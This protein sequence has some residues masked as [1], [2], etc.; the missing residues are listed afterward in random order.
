MARSRADQIGAAPICGAIDTQD[1]S[2]G[3]A[4]LP[5]IGGGRVKYCLNK[6]ELVEAWG[7]ASK[8]VDQ[9]LW[10]TKHCPDD[11]WLVIIRD[12]SPGVELLIDRESADAA[13]RRYLRGERPP[14]MP[15][16]IKSKKAA[17]AKSKELFG[18]KK[19]RGASS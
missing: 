6:K 17:P 19:W 12:G 1:I 15:S 7:G 5:F 9:M 16:Q 11:K 10:A 13:Y 14:L 3:T 8:I 2:S 4:L 18:G